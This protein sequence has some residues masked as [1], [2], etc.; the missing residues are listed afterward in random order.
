M[1]KFN[2]PLF[3]EPREFADYLPTFEDVMKFCLL[4]RRK[5]ME[6]TNNMKEPCFKGKIFFRRL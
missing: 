6:E 5:V 3:G 4:E 1:D 2:C